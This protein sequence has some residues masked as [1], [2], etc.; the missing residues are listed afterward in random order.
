MLSGGGSPVDRFD[1]DFSHNAAKETCDAKALST[2]LSCCVWE[3]R[4]V[5]LEHPNESWAGQRRAGPILVGQGLQLELQI[6][7]SF[8][9]SNRNLGCFM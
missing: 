6:L 1:T 9:Q 3:P 8:A 2:F 4:R 5:G 7:N